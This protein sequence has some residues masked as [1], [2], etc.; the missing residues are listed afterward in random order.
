MEILLVKKLIIRYYG[1]EFVSCCIKLFALSIRNEADN[2]NFLLNTF[3]IKCVLFYY[4][5]LQEI[6]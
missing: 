2:K 5:S 1:T 3:F 4:F 6:L